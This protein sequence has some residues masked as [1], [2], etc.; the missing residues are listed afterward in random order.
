MGPGRMQK[1][2]EL[3]AMLLMG[4]AACSAEHKA[5]APQPV[6]P[7]DVK[8]VVRIQVAPLG[9][10]PP[11]TF[12]LTYRMSS[13]TLGFIDDDHVLFTFRVSGLLKRMPQDYRNDDPQEIR[14]VV[15]DL[16]T[17]KVMRQTEWRMYDR[18]AYLWPYPAGKFLVRV[19]D[20][21]YLTDASLQLR[22]YMTFPEGLRQ[23]EVSPDRSLTVLETN[24]PAKPQTQGFYSGPGQMPP[25]KVRILPSGSKDPIAESESDRAVMIPLMPDGIVNMLEGK[26]QTSWVM[27]E[28]PFRGKPKLVAGIQSTCRPAAQPLSARVVLITTCDSKG[29]DH[30]VMAISTDGRELWQDRWES[31]YI[32]GWYDYAENGSRF[33]YESLKVTR[34]IGFLDP[35]YPSDIA[36]EMVGVYDTETG[37][38]VLVK[39]ASPILTAGQNVAL[40][41]DGRRFAIL[42]D[43]AVEVYDLPP[44]S[45]PK[46]EAIPT[47]AKRK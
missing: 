35:L 4:A 2:A 40:S 41:S 21:L 44:I 16:K 33:A 26:K 34:A 23:V 31:R 13:A 28:V 30:V 43:G 12:Y 8:P 29:S 10:Q 47:L 27:Q 45:K 38:M 5:P 18:S 3:A 1:V 9:Y 46:P 37:K 42:R 24:L 32:W 11:S 22:P 14:A 36:A 7:G 25:V 19:G 6:S 17:G 15:L 20:S 39:A